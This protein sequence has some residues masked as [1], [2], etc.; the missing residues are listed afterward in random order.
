MLQLEPESSGF[1]E[2]GGNQLFSLFVSLATL[3]VSV[4]LMPL[5]ANAATD[6]ASTTPVADLAVATQSS[7]PAKNGAQSALSPAAR[8][9]TGTAPSPPGSASAVLPTVGGMSAGELT[10]ILKEQHQSR[11]SSI[12]SHVIGTG[13]GVTVMAKPAKDADDRAL[14]I[15]AVFFAKTL[16]DTAPKQIEQVDVIFSRPRAEESKVIKI[17]KKAIITYGEG[18]MSAEA[19]LSMLHLRPVSS[20]ELPAV[21]PGPFRERRLLIC[22]RIESLRKTGTGVKPFQTIFQSIESAIKSGDTDQ[23]KSELQDIEDKLTA[24]EEQ[25]AIAKRTA[26]GRGL[27]VKSSSTSKGDTTRASGKDDK[28][29]DKDKDD[30]DLERLKRNFRENSGLA[31]RRIHNSENAGKL[32][33]LKRV[34]DERMASGRT[35]DVRQSIED[36]WKLAGQDSSKNF[37]RRDENPVRRFQGASERFNKFREDRGD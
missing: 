36:F 25:V 6:T 8:P 26:L 19:F 32:I 28:N 16:V 33:D 7:P 21:E 37:L 5:T 4:V 18:N 29:K 20:D 13:P 23:I 22:E 30:N 10:V 3:V 12:A 2:L 27:T 31:I 1:S 17:S 9:Q 34:I 15:D 11:T 14:K 35:G 24:Q